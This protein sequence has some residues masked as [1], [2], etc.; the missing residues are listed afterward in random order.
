[1][2]I[3]DFNV[4]LGAH[5]KTRLAPLSISCD[6]LHSFIEDFNL[7]HLDMVNSKF[8]WVSMGIKRLSVCL[9][10]S[11]LFYLFKLLAFG[12]LSSLYF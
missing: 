4:V 8:T 6:E 7:L 9:I 11:L 10:G 1:M 3:G 2:V 12:F 5:E